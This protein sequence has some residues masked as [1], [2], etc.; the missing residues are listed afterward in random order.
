MNEQ[1]TIHLERTSSQIAKITFANPPVNLIV[2]ETVVRLSEI[3]DELATDPDIQV[4][5]FD[6]G[7]PLPVRD[8]GDNSG[9]GACRCAATRFRRWTCVHAGTE[10]GLPALGGPARGRVP[11][12]DARLCR[13]A[14]RLA[15][16]A[17][18]LT[19]RC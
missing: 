13:S 16:A 1:S 11:R 14:I 7:V 15:M 12:G 17:V 3:V 18:T 5:V 6:S 10:R 19:R 8:C 9:H 2:R 4:V